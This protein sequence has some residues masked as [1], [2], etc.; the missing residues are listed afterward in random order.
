VSTEDGVQNKALRQ[1][2]DSTDIAQFTVILCC[3]LIQHYLT[4]SKL[5]RSVNLRPLGN[6][7]RGNSENRSVSVSHSECVCSLSE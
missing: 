7:K 3:V 1:N 5:A 6:P 4:V 2:D